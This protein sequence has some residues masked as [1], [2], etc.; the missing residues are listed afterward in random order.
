M[1]RREPWAA[2]VDTAG[3][4]FWHSMEHAGESEWEALMQRACARR[5]ETWGPQV[6]YSRKVFIPLT[7]LCRDTC[8]YCTFAKQP[9]EAGAGYLT[10]DEVMDIVRRGQGLGCK[11]ALFS[12]G[13]RPELRYSEARDTLAKLGHATTLDYVIKVCERVLRE[14]TLIPHV[15]AGTLSVDELRR[16]KAVSG[17]VGLML[18]MRRL[19]A[20]AT[21]F[22]PREG[23]RCY[24]ALQCSTTSK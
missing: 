12:L 2:H 8:G 15:N 16:I 17:S 23:Y 21:L 20:C 10:P 22:P 5:D 3:V 11:E 9:G 18:A 14:S 13:E 24:K 1:K 7:N 6:T 19:K 4:L